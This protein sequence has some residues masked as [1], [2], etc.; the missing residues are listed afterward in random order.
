MNRGIAGTALRPGHSVSAKAAQL[1]SQPKHR[2]RAR[3]Q[4]RQSTR[5]RQRQP[6]R[7]QAQRGTASKSPATLKDDG[8]K[9][10]YR[11]GRKAIFSTAVNL[12]G[13]FSSIGWNRKTNPK[14]QTPRLRP[15]YSFVPTP[16]PL[17]F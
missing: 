17:P 10:T 14:K 6:G 7:Q 13:R 15:N 11:F 2:I 9:T 16:I 5:H 8:A 12:K 1:G 3:Q 4:G